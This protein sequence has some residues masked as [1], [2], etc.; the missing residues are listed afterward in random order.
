MAPSSQ[1][2][3]TVINAEKD[4]DGLKYDDAPVPKVGENEVLVKL[5]GASLNYR[6][7]IIPKVPLLPLFT[8]LAP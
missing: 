4:F 2:Q 5:H 3:W 1:K 6:D 7:L 8:S